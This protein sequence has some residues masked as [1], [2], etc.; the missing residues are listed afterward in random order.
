MSLFKGNGKGSHERPLSLPLNIKCSDRLTEAWRS[1][2]NRSWVNM[3]GLCG[4]FGASLAMVI[5]RSHSCALAVQCCRLMTL[6]PFIPL[7]FNYHPIWSL[8]FLL[9]QQWRE[10]SLLRTSKPVWTLKN[11]PYSNRSSKDSGYSDCQLG[12]PTRP[13]R[14]QRKI[15]VSKRDTE[16]STVLWRV[17][18][19]FMPLDQYAT[20]SLPLAVVFEGQTIILKG[21]THLRVVRCWSWVPFDD[22]F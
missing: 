10:N 12:V 17:L 20:I 1:V 13:I 19:H 7:P 2:W 6:A 14:S 9:P 21:V 5:M 11:P 15:D 16:E 4:G 22:T 3:V 18:K 8:Q